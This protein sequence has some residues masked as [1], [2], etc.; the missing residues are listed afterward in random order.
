MNHSVTEITTLSVYIHAVREGGAAIE[1]PE[2]AKPGVRQSD[3]DHLQIQSCILRLV[4]AEFTYPQT[5]NGVG[6]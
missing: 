1:Q 4:R 6:C 5:I 2:E 3:I